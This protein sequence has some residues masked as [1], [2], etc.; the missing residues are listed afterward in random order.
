[1]STTATSDSSFST[2]IA[3]QSTRDPDECCPLFDASPWDETTHIWKNKLFLKDEIRQLLHVPVRMTEHIQAMFKEVEN[4]NAVPTGK[5]FLILTHELSPWKSELYMSVS[6][7][8]PGS[9]ITPISGT[10]FSKVFD[11]PYSD[12][13]K[14]ITETNA[15]LES[16]NQ[17]VLT[18]YFHYAYCPKCAKKYGHNYCVVLAQI[19]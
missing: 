5:D 11:G 2:A 15:I 7:D 16:R 1:M 8:I 6:K 10:F 13:H 19:E 14:W 4:A 17:K 9:S 12:M 3:E 18:H